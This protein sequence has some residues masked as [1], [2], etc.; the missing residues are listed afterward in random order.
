VP[1]TDKASADN[2]ILSHVRNLC[3]PEVFLVIAT[4]GKSLDLSGCEGMKAKLPY[5]RPPHSSL[6][7]EQVRLEI[8]IFLEALQSYPDRAAREPNITFEQHLSSLVAPGHAV[9]PRRD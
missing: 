9:P 7:A 6:S 2:L 3:I 4:L 5:E 8:Q 1:F